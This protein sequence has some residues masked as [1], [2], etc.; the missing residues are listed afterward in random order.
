MS[1]DNQFY[2]EGIQFGDYVV[3][4]FLNSKSVFEIIKDERVLKKLGF[5]FRQEIENH[6]KYCYSILEKAEFI[7]SHEAPT[8]TTPLTPVD[9]SK[10]VLDSLKASPLSSNPT[11]TRVSKTLKVLAE[12]AP[13]PSTPS[14]LS[15]KSDNVYKSQAPMKIFGVLDPSSRAKRRKAMGSFEKDG[16]FHTRAY[17]GFVHLCG[18]ALEWPYKTADIDFSNFFT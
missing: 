9:V 11:H 5:K 18:G 2:S 8:P 14:G 16:S 17:G 3:N 1:Q 4:E 7:T 10:S 12:T 6:R 15:M 13:V